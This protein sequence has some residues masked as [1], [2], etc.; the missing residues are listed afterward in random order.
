MIVDDNKTIRQLIRRFVGPGRN[1][2]VECENGREAIEAYRLHRPDWVLMD[3]MMEGIDGLTATREIKDAFP[4]AKIVIITSY[5][6]DDL[7]QTA[8]EAG[9]CGYVLKE[10]LMEVL[11]LMKSGKRI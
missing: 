11:T 6:D 4:E 3:V 5:D 1:K 8:A 10:N 9:A 7:R 2:F